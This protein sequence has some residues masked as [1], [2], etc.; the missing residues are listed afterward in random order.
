MLTDL[1]LLFFPPLVFD[2]FCHCC[3]VC[4]HSDQYDV[5]VRKSSVL[6]QL[7]LPKTKWQWTM[8]MG[9]TMSSTRG[10]CM[11]SKFIFPS[12]LLPQ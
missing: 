5:V 4:D 10:M 11:D 3:A 6:D 9:K 2:V 8:G 1:T 7:R 12:L